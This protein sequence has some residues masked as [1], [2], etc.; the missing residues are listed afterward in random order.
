MKTVFHVYR[1]NKSRKTVIVGDF[2]TQEAAQEA[3]LKH[4][5]NTPKRGQFWYVISED[6]LRDIDGVVFRE[7]CYGDG[8]YHKTFKA[9]EIKAIAEAG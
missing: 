4:Y 9:E 3:M 5:R 2:D 7:T 1:S 8:S 6:T